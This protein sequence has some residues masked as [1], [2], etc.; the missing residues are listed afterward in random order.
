MTIE[1]HSHQRLDPFGGRPVRASKP[2]RRERVRALRANQNPAIIVPGFL[3]PEPE[4][5][6]A[7][8]PIRNR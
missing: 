5:F 3:K 6:P 4:N 7:R 8:V 1:L 2:A